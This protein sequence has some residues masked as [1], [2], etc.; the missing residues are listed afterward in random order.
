MGEQGLRAG[1]AQ[2]RCEFGGEPFG[3]YQPVGEAKVLA[4][5]VRMDPQSLGQLHGV[6]GGAPDDPEQLPERLPLGMPGTG[7][8]LVLG[9]ERVEAG[10]VADVDV[11]DHAEPLEELEVAIR[12]GEIAAA[13]PAPEP[14]R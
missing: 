8:P 1:P 5:D 2:H 13:H 9:D 3:D 7:R 12:G 4:H 6:P 14:A 11:A 10:T